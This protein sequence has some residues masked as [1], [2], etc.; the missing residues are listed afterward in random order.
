MF[1]TNE[2]HS[3]VSRQKQIKNI[4]LR[5]GILYLLHLIVEQFRIRASSRTFYLIDIGKSGRARK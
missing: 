5:K 1:V 2:H 4:F 3:I